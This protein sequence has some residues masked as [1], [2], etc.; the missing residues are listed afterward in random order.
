ME[1]IKIKSFKKEMM[2][3]KGKTLLK[4]EKSLLW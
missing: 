3:L 1:K 2:I 4:G